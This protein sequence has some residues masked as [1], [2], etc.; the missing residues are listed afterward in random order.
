MTELQHPSNSTSNAARGLHPLPPPPVPSPTS[1]HRSATPTISS[2]TGSSEGITLEQIIQQAFDMGY[3][4]IHLGVGEVP[5]FR[6]RGEI[7]TTDYPETDKEIFM[8]WLR[9]VLTDAEIHRFEEQ[10][11]F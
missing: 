3:S 6:N 1:T 9:E 8:S 10:L 7:Q 11:E 4:D 2:P 5:R